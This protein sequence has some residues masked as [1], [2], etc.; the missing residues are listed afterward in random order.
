M[1]HIMEGRTTVPGGDALAT[2]RRDGMFWGA[3]RNRD[4]MNPWHDNVKDI[5]FYL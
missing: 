2:Y 5:M 1:K 3:G 4:N